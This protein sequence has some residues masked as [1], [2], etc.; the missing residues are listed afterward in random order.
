MP[1]RALKTSARRL[2]EK[3]VAVFRFDKRGAG[4]SD[5]VYQRGLADFGLLA[6]DPVA[7]VDFVI[8][9]TRV[10]A[11]RI[12]LLGASQAGRII[13]IAATRSEHVA[14]T[15]LLSGPAGHRRA[16]QFLGRDRRRR[17]PDDLTALGHARRGQAAGRRFRS[18]SVYRGDDSIGALAAWRS[19]PNH[20]GARECSDR[21][22]RRRGVRKAL[23]GHRHPNG[24]HGLRDVDSGS[25]DA[26][27]LGRSP[28]LAGLRDPISRRGPRT[29][30]LGTGKK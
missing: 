13:P 30:D 3:E 20:P 18:P 6:G 14:F 27:L 15:I 7:A 1:H 10:D 22:G 2:V 25:R 12:G 21:H 8:P 26:D 17:E 16:A 9:D 11:T 19:G 29:Q 4:D 28:A 23:H 5:G 24:D